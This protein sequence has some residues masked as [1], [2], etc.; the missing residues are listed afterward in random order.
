MRN[1]RG[2]FY[3]IAAIFIVLILFGATT[4][5]TYVIVKSNPRTISEVSSE[6]DREVYNIIEYGIYNNENL[7]S[8]ADSFAGNDVAKYFLKKTNDANIVF[9]YGNKSNVNAL[10]FE[11]ANTGIIKIG[12]ANF[13]V[14]NSFSKKGKLVPKD[15]FVEIEILNK[16]YSFE[17][18]NNEIFYFI[19]VQKRGEEVFIQ[20]NKEIDNLVKKKKPGKGE[21]GSIK[22]NI[23][24]DDQI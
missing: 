13:E 14:H 22:G 7:T 19:I 5:S 24:E 16:N 6:L 2:Q 4:I 20:R 23:K 18:K 1:K 12:G 17:L 11:N 8:L 3:I 21:L 10:H 9:V 15:G